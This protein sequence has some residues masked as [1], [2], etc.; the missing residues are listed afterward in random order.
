ML[1]LV[2]F[3]QRVSSNCQLV[4]NKGLYHALLAIHF[5]ILYSA[6]VT[7]LTK[8]QGHPTHYYIIL[9][10]YHLEE[11]RHHNDKSQ[12]DNFDRFDLNKDFSVLV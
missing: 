10:L 1:L 5:A 11:Y 2:Q 3:V 9:L 8:Y 4:R 6:L 7:Q 12:N